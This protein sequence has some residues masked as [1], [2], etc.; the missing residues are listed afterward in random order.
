MKYDEK[1]VLL[2]ALKAGELMLKSG[3]ET[4]RVEDTAVRICRACG[5]ED[6]DVFV[7][8]TGLFLTVNGSG[9]NTAV[10]SYIK[11][12]RGARTDLER[13]SQLNALSRRLET[14]EL[15]L[16]D[17]EQIVDNISREEQFSFPV[18]LLGAMMISSCFTLMFNGGLT[19]FIS[20]LIVGALTYL[21][22]MKLVVRLQLNWFIET[23]L[24]CAFATSLAIFFTHV[25]LGLNF[26]PIIIGSLMIF[27]PGVMITNAVRDILAGDTVSGVS[28]AADAI[29][30]ALSIAMG[31]AAVMVLY[32]GMGGVL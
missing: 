32:S 13:I 5:V 27:F 6:A 8:P 4:A 18:R 15:T 30:T 12:I 25:G 24:C 29:L 26:D 1:R 14:G 31:A 7:M 16:E 2:L 19:D 11:R 22:Q 28:R 17:A 20:S 3:G 9:D 10:Q 21:L 23:F